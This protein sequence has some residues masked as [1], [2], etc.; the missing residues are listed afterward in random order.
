MDYSAI[1]DQFDKVIRYSQNISEPKTEELFATWAE[2]KKEF[3]KL[4]NGLI[5][6]Y[7]EKVSFEL[8]AK[9][10][11]NRVIEFANR[12]HEQYGYYSLSRF[13]EEQEEGFFKN[14]SI[15]DATG[16]DGKVVKKGTKL[17]RA[18]KHFVYSEDS[19]SLTDIQNEASRI[20]QEDKIEGTLC[21]SV[22]PL[23]F[24]SVSENTYNWRSCHSLDGEYRAGNLS[25]MKDSCTF[26]CYLKGADDVVL[27]GFG[28]DV[29]WNSKKWRV[30][31]YL[32]QDQAMIMAGRQ[33]PFS[34]ANGLDT[35]LHKVLH[36]AGICYGSWTDWNDDYVDSMELKGAKTLRFGDKYI[37]IRYGLKPLRSVVKNAYSSLQFNDLLE[38]SCY[39]PVYSFKHFD[40]GFGSCCP[41]T[42]EGSTTFVIGDMVDCLQCGHDFILKGT[43]SMMCADCELQYG[44][45]NNDLITYCDCCGRRVF[46]DDTYNTNDGTICPQCI[47]RY[48]RACDC[49]GDYVREDEMIYEAETENYVC[50]YCHEEGD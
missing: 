33:Y 24:L 30:L 45:G 28:P 34:S 39:T 12:V 9:E 5:Y 6:E 14:I 3:I 16:I 11:H 38:S 21:L 29:R 46:I 18:F 7:P 27:P 19:K 23:D 47:D 20:I 13:I 2:K 31:L 37:P 32:S 10:R 36:T 40:N 15:A 41:A 48:Y 26:I 49:C 22:H 43:N 44:D 4:F 50:R 25:Y 42:M 8:S 17:V 1:K 35:V